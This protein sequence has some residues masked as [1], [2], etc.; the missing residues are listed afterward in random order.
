MVPGSTL[1]YGSNFCSVTLSPRLSSR[2]P[3]DAAAMPLPRDE[4]TPPVTKMYL[5]VGIP[6]FL[7]CQKRFKESCYTF[8]IP[9]C[10]HAERLIFGFDH[11]DAIPVLDRPQL[12]QLFSL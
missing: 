6:P 2:Q 9:G 8:E 10:I 12:L 1:R 11:A 5:V 3:M 7:F 4:T